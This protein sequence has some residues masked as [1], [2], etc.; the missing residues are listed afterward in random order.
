[1][2]R[3]SV[4]LTCCFVVGCATAKS[5]ALAELKALE[6]Q[7]SWSELRGKLKAVPATER[8]AEWEGLVERAAVNELASIEIKDPYS[9]ESALAQIAAQAEAYPSLKKS[10]DWLA[11]RADV[12]AKAFGWTYSNYR[13]STSDEEWV[14]KVKAFVEADA[15]TKGL[16][17]RFGKDVIAGRLVA[18]SA[19]PLYKLAFTREG[20]S[21]CADSKLLDVVVDVIDYESW[22]DEMKPL[23]TQRCAAQLKAPII[24]KLKKNDSKG[25]R[26]GACKV[27]EGQADA[28]EAL[29]VCAT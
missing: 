3:L 28:A 1:M 19:W 15:V 26:K 24:E 27:L 7:Q 18:S 9:G 13:H 21:V 14:P 11:K 25:F 23:V 16:A 12:G 22:L 8:D 17:Q 20:D 6:Q 5:G 10:V 2:H 4:V 29:K